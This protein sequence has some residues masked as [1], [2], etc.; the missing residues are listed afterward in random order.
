MAVAGC[1]RRWLM[2]SVPLLS[3]SLECNLATGHLQ[4]R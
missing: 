4:R 3:G 1:D 2:S